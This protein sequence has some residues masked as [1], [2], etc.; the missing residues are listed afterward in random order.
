MIVVYRCRRL[1]FVRVAPFPGSLSVDLVALPVSLPSW[2]WRGVEVVRRDR[3][4]RCLCRP[5]WVAAVVRKGLGRRRL[6]RLWWRQGLP[7]R[8]AAWE[9]RGRGLRHP[10]QAWWRPGSSSR[11]RMCSSTGLRRRLT[12][13]RGRR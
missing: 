10:G 12:S 7:L 3:G 4:L 5:L 13:S 11:R 9:R 8:D 2:P 1:G 6:G